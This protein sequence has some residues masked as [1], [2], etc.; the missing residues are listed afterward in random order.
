MWINGVRTYKKTYTY[1]L[2]PRKRGII[3][4]GQATIDVKG[5]TYKTSPVKIEVTAAVDKPKDP[6]DPSFIASNNV[7]LVAEVSNS[8]PY[9]NEAIT[10]I[11]KLYVAPNTGVNN[12]DEIDIPKYND[13]WSQTID[14]KDQRV[15][16]GTFKGEEYRFLVLRKT[17]LYP[18]KSGKLNIEPLTLD[19]SVQV[20]TNRRD[21][22]GGVVMGS[23]SKKVSA[24]NKTIRI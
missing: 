4:I 1:F 5:K 23:A 21:F 12:W 2:E 15:Q 13:F 16:T 11:Y 17:V 6:N 24:G 14:T 18:Q 9:L 22:F 3:S 19:V 20:P 8:N 10:V 7:H